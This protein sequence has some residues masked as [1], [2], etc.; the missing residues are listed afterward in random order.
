MARSFNGNTD[1][2]LG[3]SINGPNP[4][5]YGSWF[6]CT[7]V[8]GYNCTLCNVADMKLYVTSSGKLAIYC[9]TGLYDGTGTHTVT[10]NT[11]H[12]FLATFDGATVTGY[13]DGASDASFAATFSGSASS[14]EIGRDGV[15]GGHNFGGLLADVAVWNVVL[16]QL[17]ISALANGARPLAVRPKALVRYWPVG[18]LQSP[19]P[20]LSGNAQNGTLTG[21]NPAFGPPFAPY[22]PRWPQFTQLP[23]APSFILMPQ[24]VM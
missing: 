2:I 13:L 16:S 9:F 1:L 3:G 10:A 20:D 14:N 4:C 19:E 18:G 8:K 5:T 15:G 21:T 17:E 7:L 12:Y 6:N 22:T 24:I 11:W 23:I